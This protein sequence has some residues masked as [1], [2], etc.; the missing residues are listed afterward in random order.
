MHPQ[1]ALQ[2]ADPEVEDRSAR[3]ARPAGLCSLSPAELGTLYSVSSVLSIVGAPLGGYM[4]DVIGRKPAIVLGS[5]VA[6]ASLALI[7]LVDSKLQLMGVMAGMGFGEAFLMSANAALAN[8]VTPAPLRGAQAALLAQV[9]DVT[10]VVMPIALGLL[11]TSVSYDAAFLVSAS[12]IAGSNVGF[13]LLAK[14][15]LTPPA[16]R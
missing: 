7:P 6:A 5:G 2:R 14:Q 11:A 12:L 4:A 9:G 16:V 3:A 1:S 8:D 10:F 13:A 15:P